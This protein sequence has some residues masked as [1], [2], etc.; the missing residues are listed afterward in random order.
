[1]QDIA[2]RDNGAAQAKLVLLSEPVLEAP[3]HKVVFE[4][5]PVAVHNGAFAWSTT[6]LNEARAAEGQPAPLLFI[7]LA[8]V[9]T[10][11]HT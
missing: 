10:A 1:M 3:V 6:V 9:P 4:H 8:N 2:S 5:V 7:Q 11:S